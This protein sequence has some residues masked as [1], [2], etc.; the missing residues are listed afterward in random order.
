MNKR[1]VSVTIIGCIFIVAGVV[2]LTYHA[3]DFRTVRPAEYALVC[4]V[5]LLA[6]IG[7]AFLLR[8]RDWARWLLVAWMAWHV[9]LSVLHTPVELVMHAVLLVVAAWFLFQPKTS[10][11]FRRAREQEGV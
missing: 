5:R 2:G 4:F 1:P 3:G 8:T 11:Y 7:G 10:M 6:I 9:A